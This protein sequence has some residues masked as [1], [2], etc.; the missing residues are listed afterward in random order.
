MWCYVY[1]C[2]GAF[3]GLFAILLFFGCAMAI[4][5]IEEHW[6]YFVAIPGAIVGVLLLIFLIRCLIKLPGKI[7]AHIEER[8]RYKAEIKE[9]V[10]NMWK[11]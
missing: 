6:V 2:G 5:F 10:M 1:C 8:R 11:H 4:D 9:L 3:S 7:K